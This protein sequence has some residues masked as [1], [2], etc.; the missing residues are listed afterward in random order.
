MRKWIG[1]ALIAFAVLAL[2]G[3]G[4][5][6]YIRFDWDFTPDSFYATDSNI[7]GTVTRGTEYE[8]SPGYYYFESWWW[9]GASWWTYGLYYTLSTNSGL[10]PQD[11]IYQIYC[12]YYDYPEIDKIQG[13]I[14]KPAGDDAMTISAG[15][16]PEGTRELV[17]SFELDEA[18]LGYA[19]RVEI[20][21]IVP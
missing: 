10:F 18:K 5:A 16:P 13:L 20:S 8:T 4:S 2:A 15:T 6:V 9:D 3:C 1:L 19:G 17:Y 11:S 7:P 12:W 21:R 14:P